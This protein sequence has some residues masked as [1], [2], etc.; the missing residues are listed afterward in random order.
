[1][2]HSTQ[3]R[4]RTNICRDKT[5]QALFRAPATA[6]SSKAMCNNK[7]A[8][9]E[10]PFFVII[11]PYCKGPHIFDPDEAYKY[12]YGKR[13]GMHKV[14]RFCCTQGSPPMYDVCSSPCATARRM[15]TKTIL[16]G[17]HLI[18]V[19]TNW[20]VLGLLVRKLDDQLL[21]VANAPT[22]KSSNGRLRL[23]F[24]RV[25]QKGAALGPP[26]RP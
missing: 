11:G 23:G 2:R 22:M 6:R 4:Q 19:S 21:A 7:E 5:N 24:S 9:Q 18:I 12:I 15:N 16:S 17:R 26:L 3:G 25:R 14:R 1:M 20:T 13:E 8:I 10:A